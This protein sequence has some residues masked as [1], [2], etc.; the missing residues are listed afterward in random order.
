MY[1]YIY[2]LTMFSNGYGIYLHIILID[3]LIKCVFFTVYFNNGLCSLV[4]G[5]KCSTCNPCAEKLISCL[6]CI[7]QDL[8]VSKSINVEYVRINSL[9]IAMYHVWPRDLKMACLV[10][11]TQAWLTV[12]SLF[13]YK[14]FVFDIRDR[15]HLYC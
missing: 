4:Y 10:C 2:H 7:A 15:S 1:I 12:F 13:C 11:L 5:S 9:V 8:K 14:K 3:I 6:L